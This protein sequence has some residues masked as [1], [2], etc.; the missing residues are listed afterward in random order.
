MQIEAGVD[1]LQIFDSWAGHLP[2]AEFKSRILPG[3]KIILDAIRPFPTIVFTRGSCHL[4]DELVS[5]EPTGIGFD[6]DLPISEVRRRVPKHIAVQGNL[7]PEILR[8]DAQTI[9]N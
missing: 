6:W 5:L 3:L 7:N 1:A 8:L 9:K 2:K 4:I